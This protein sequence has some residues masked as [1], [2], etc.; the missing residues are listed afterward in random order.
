M[1]LGVRVISRLEDTLHGG[2]PQ[3]FKRGESLEHDH[4]NSDAWI[5]LTA[6]R[7]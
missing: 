5:E 4:G 1:Y 7:R 3:S 2:L 6:R